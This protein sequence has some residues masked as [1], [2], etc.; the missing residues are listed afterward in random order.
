MPRDFDTLRRLQFCYDQLLLPV[1]IRDNRAMEILTIPPLHPQARQVEE[2][3]PSHSRSTRSQARAQP[4]QEAEAP[5]SEQAEPRRE[6]EAPPSQHAGPMQEAEAPPSEVAEP[7]QE[8]KGPR[9]VCAETDQKAEVTPE[10][11]A[12]KGK[13]IAFEEEDEEMLPKPP[14]QGES[15]RDSEFKQPAP[16]TITG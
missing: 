11:D 16:S 7:E 15:S 13:Q 12:E 8:A 4:E 6:A 14:V 9:D 5:P 2:S 1:P 3:P 10:R